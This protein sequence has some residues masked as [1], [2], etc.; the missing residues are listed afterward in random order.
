MFF[1]FINI[2]FISI[3][4]ANAALEN[5]VKIL[6]AELLSFQNTAWRNENKSSELWIFEYNV[7]DNIC[8]SIFSMDFDGKAR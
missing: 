8:M 4:I 1:L 3:S 6:A 2:T 5:C 7:I